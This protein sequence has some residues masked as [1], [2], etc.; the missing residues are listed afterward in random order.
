[1]YIVHFCIGACTVLRQASLTRAYVHQEI[2][3]PFFLFRMKSNYKLMMTLLSNAF[4]S[5][6]YIFSRTFLELRVLGI[7]I[8]LLIREVPLLGNQF[9]TSFVLAFLHVTRTWLYHKFK[10]KLLLLSLLLLLY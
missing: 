6:F 4:L 5:Y 10:L 2:K 9:C 3:I 1:M 7:Q 8:C